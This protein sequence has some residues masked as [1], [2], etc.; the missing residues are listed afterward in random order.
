[1]R[2]G[3]PGWLPLKTNNNSDLSADTRLFT[4]SETTFKVVKGTVRIFI[5]FEFEH[6]HVRIN[7]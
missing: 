5:A 3:R 6:Q 4:F 2:E 7:V 1:M